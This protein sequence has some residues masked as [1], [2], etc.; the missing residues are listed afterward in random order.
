MAAPTFIFGGDGMP[1]TPQELARLRAVATALAPSRAPRDV[2]E[3]LSS[4]G[5]AIAYRLM[6][7]KAAAGEKAGK[8]TA[9]LDFAPFLS[10]GGAGSVSPSGGSSDTIPMSDAAGEVSGTSPGGTVDMTGNDVYSGF[11]DTVKA[12]GVTNP[13]ALAAIAATGKAES[14]FNPKNATRTW[15]DPSESGQAG[16]AGGIMSWRGPR[17]QALAATGDLSPQGQAKFFLGENPQLIAQLQSAKSVEEAQSLMNN[18][19]KFAGYN[20]PGGEAGRRLGYANS[21]LPAFQG[22][23]EVAAVSPDAAFNAV[24][25]ELGGGIPANADPIMRKNMTVPSLSDEVSEFRN[26]PEFMQAYPGGYTQQPLT[27]QQFNDRFAGEQAGQPTQASQGVVSALT[28]GGAQS[29]GQQA[30]NNQTRVA[31]AL[32]QNGAMSDAGGGNT[33]YFPAAPSND[34]GVSRAQVLRAL[35]NPFL[36]DEQKAIVQDEY[37]RMQQNADPLRQLQLRKLQREV[38]S[39]AKQWQRLDNT[40]LFDPATGEIKR[41]EAGANATPS[42]LGLNPQYGVDE[43]GNPVILQLGKDGKVIKSKMPDGVTLSKEPL[44]LDAGT[45]FVLLDSITRQPIGQIPKNLAEA[46]TE[47]AVGKAEGEARSALPAVEGTANELLSSID[48]LYD[49]PY[50]PNMLGPIDSRLPNLSADSARVQSKM[51][52]IGGQAFM[53]AFN[54]LRGAGQIT[55]QEGAKATAAMARLS[56]AQSEK[57]YKAALDELRGVVK[58]A[59]GQSRQKAGIEGQADTA[60]QGKRL[61]F[62]PATGELE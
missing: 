3:G 36:S 9:A 2:G 14:G 44:R 19:W 41:I 55:E 57:D 4:I 32:T 40:T 29:G 54:N 49:D 35:S 37:Q 12:G 21:F 52:Q 13:Y 7:N 47:K 61:K 5:N 22:G 11:M 15:S 51:D 45:H 56:T 6:M 30:I 46:E 17:Y 26:T 43:N 1:K 24:M 16:T 31:Q 34:G 39:P 18:A 48:S 23:G 62:N 58:R 50:L 33:D 60:T 27:D 20:R 53:Q 8:E 25:P 10:G 28:A 42:D 38:E 59:M